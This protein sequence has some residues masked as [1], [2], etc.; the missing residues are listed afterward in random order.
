M[1]QEST[2][3]LTHKCEVR[4]RDVAGGKSVI[5]RN[6]IEPGELIAVWSGSIVG[7]EE[8]EALPEEFR[9][10]TVQVEE[11]LYLASCTPAEPPDFINH[12]C[13]PN[14][15]LD[16]QIV[17]VALQRILPGQEVAIDY[18]MCDGSPYDEFECVCGTPSCRGR[19]TGEDWRNPVLWKRYAG[20]FSPYLRRRIEALQRARAPRRPRRKRVL[21]LAAGGREAP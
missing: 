7:F 12:S 3:Y 13:E 5:A 21:A 14:A 18:A 19:V 4:N 8:F 11:G 20:H 15:G 9:R 16:G 1:S 10:H 2:A 6:V 17:I